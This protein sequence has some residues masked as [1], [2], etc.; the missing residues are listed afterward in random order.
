MTWKFENEAVP[1][2]VFPPRNLRKGPARSGNWVEVYKEEMDS[3]TPKPV[4]TTLNTTQ[5]TT[6]STT[7]KSVR[8]KF[9]FKSPDIHL[10]PTPDDIFLQVKIISAP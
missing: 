2:N 6:Q 8:I 7:P 3:T 1:V 9:N 5:R 4:S 10:T